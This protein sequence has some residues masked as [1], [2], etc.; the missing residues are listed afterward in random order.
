M[1]LTVSFGQGGK[2]SQWYL[3]GTS[4]ALLPPGPP[5][6]QPPAADAL[7]GGAYAAAWDDALLF[8]ALVEADTIGGTA[9]SFDVVGGWNSV[10]NAF[11]QSDAAEDLRFDG[12][13]QVDID[14][15]RADADGASIVTVTGAKRGNIVTGEGDD[16]IRVEMLSNE[17]SWNNEFRIVTG[18]GDDVV[19]LAGLNRDHE[20]AGGDTTYAEFANGAGG[21]WDV[22]GRMTRSFV[23]LGAGNDRFIGHGSDDTV[24]GG[25]GDDLADGGEGEDVWVLSGHRDSYVI[26]R[27]GDRTLITDNDT[28][29]GNDGRDNIGNFERVRFGDGS[30]ILLT[31]LTGLT[32]WNR[33]GDAGEVAASEIGPDGTLAGGTFVPGVFGGAWRA[34]A[35]DAT[36]YYGPPDMRG[37]SFP[38]SVINPEQGTI[39]VW[40]RLEGFSGTVPVGALPGIFTTLPAPDGTVVPVGWWSLAFSNNDGGGGG[41]LVGQAGDANMTGTSQAGAGGTYDSLLGG[42]TAAWH[43]LAFSW[44]QYGIAGIGAPGREVM[45]FIDGAPVSSHFEEHV[46]RSIGPNG[47]PVYSSG[48]LVPPV[49]DT[50]VLA[51][52]GP[53]WPEGMAVAFDDLKVWSV[54]KT[55][56]SDRF[57]EGAGALPGGDWVLWSRANGGNDHWYRLVSEPATL[58]FE[59]AA[60]AA[61]ALVPGSHLA[62]VTSAG[63]NAFIA[64]LAA[65]IDPIGQSLVWIGGVQEPGSSEPSGGWGWVTGEEFGYTNWYASVPSGALPEPN[66]IIQNEDVMVMFTQTENGVPAGTWADL[67]RIDGSFRVSAYVAELD[68][69]L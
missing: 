47:E 40:V 63:E 6:G 28:S 45:L 16:I 55:E 69:L 34:T 54:A 32:L 4:T 31:T 3:P 20:L 24:T 66:D 64:S 46:L 41:G 49:G 17:A 44:S 61:A 35:S 7:T 29:D 13:V 67:N 39:E 10:K 14:I 12:F 25:E 52:D 33:L 42:D 19:E 15:G 27:L 57:E 18:G 30:E 9:H 5:G 37:L 36:T 59:E 2:P 26:T 56:F 23:D 62:T 65:R 50:L 8:G 11:A 38:S 1:A 21:I 43:H 53:P 68:S 22:S 60:T 58:G 48:A 51:F